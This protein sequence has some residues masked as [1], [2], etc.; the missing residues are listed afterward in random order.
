MACA[1]RTG[2][3]AFPDTEWH[4]LRPGYP[5]GSTTDLRLLG[6]H[7]G[8]SGRIG[9][10][11]LIRGRS[12]VRIGHTLQ[13]FLETLEAFTQTLTEFREALGSEEHKQNDCNDYQ[14]SW[15]KQ[16]AHRIILRATH[17][18]GP[19]ARML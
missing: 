9:R 15:L 3:C 1:G 17:P 16:I 12:R 10:I 18:P 6:F 5:A 7:R 11:L 14:V 4:S 19:G 8:G 2:H 13:S